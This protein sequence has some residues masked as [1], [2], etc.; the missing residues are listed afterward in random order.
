V[1]VDVSTHRYRYDQTLP[2]LQL[3]RLVEIGAVVDP[4]GHVF[5]LDITLVNDLM[6]PDLD[7]IMVEDW[8][9]VFVS[10]APF[11]RN[12][13]SLAQIR[14]TTE[15]VTGSVPSSVAGE[16]REIFDQNTQR[17]QWS[18]G[19]GAFRFPRYRSIEVAAAIAVDLTVANVI[20]VTGGLPLTVTLPSPAQDDDLVVVKDKS[21]AASL[22]T[23]ITI[24]TAG[25]ETIDGALSQDIA[26]PFESLQFLFR[27]GD[28]S[29]I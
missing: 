16:G 17:Y 20:L 25:A 28:W 3:D 15:S 21:G 1:G 9:F 11:V 10:T 5:E 7:Q 27:S 19:G 29:P 4:V 12:P 8:G 22:L 23:P 13:N 24:D 26:S 14:D 6:K 2:Q 18:E